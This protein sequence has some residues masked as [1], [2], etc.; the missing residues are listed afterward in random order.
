MFWGYLPVSIDFSGDAGLHVQTL[1]RRMRSPVDPAD[2]LSKE[3][4]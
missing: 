3:A 2:R 1:F 4:S